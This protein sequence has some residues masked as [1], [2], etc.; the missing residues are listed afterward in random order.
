MNTHSRRKPALNP[1]FLSILLQKPIK[2]SAG[3]FIQQL[4]PQE[5]FFSPGC[6]YVLFLPL[7]LSLKYSL[8]SSLLFILLSADCD[9]TFLHRQ[10]LSVHLIHLS[11][12]VTTKGRACRR[13]LKKGN[14][15][16]P[17]LIRLEN[18]QY[19]IIFI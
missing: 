10:H 12:A 6:T 13:F 15:K 4:F 7:L 18:R 1:K 14:K 17:F 16:L 19:Q 11:S 8:Q 3:L 9:V 5:L 2:I